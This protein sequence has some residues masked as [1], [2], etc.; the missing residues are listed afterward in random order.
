VGY[1]V[2]SA[3]LDPY[4]YGLL[5]SEAR[6]AVFL[7]IAKHDIPREA[8]FRLGRKLT[9]YQN[10]RVLLSWSG[11]MFEYAMPAL[12]MKS[13]DHTLLGTSVR[14]AVQVQQQ[15]ARERRV[16]WGISEAAYS[17]SDGVQERRYQAFGV[18]GLAMKR[19]PSSDLVVAPYATL[20]ALMVDAPAA[21]ANLRAMAQKHWIGRYGF[22]ESI[23]YRGRGADGMAPP[24]VVP[25]FMAHHQGMSLMGLAN[26]LFDGVMQ[27]RFHSERLVLAAELLLQERLPKLIPVGEPEPWGG[28]IHTQPAAAPLDREIATASDGAA[29]VPAS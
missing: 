20:L 4:C 5:A 2:D 24:R 15:Y 6:T 1:S 25:L 18:P 12:F 10:C 3:Q 22:F 19:M 16:P 28:G 7:A 13:Y 9:S 23:D 14:R 21:I 17:G 29:V 8:W 11:T 26:A 27:K